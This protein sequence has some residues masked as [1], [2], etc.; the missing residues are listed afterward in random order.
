MLNVTDLSDSLIK[1]LQNP[2]KEKKETSVLINNLG[3]KTL[4]DTMKNI[5]DFLFNET[6]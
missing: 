6:K 3:Q 4:A 2:F 5:N 1:D